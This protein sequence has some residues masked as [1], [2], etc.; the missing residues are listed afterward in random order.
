MGRNGFFGNFQGLDAF[1]KTME[2]VKI[3]TRTGA[4]LTFISFSIILTSMMLEFVDYRRIHLEPSI[5]VD[6]SRGE[7]LV[8]E[9]DVSFPRVPCYLLS[10]DVMDI[11]GEHQTELEHHITKKRL[12]KDGHV[13]ESIEGGQLKGDV[14]RANLK[15]DPNYCGSCY[16]AS[17]P[18]NGCCNSCE[19]VRQAY[20]RKGWS[21][22]DPTGIEQCVEEGWM[23]KMK[24]QNTEGC[25]ISGR[26]RVNK[27]I[28]NIHFSPGR[29]FQNNMMQMLE[30]VP[31]L[32][33]ANHHDFGHIIHKFRFAADLT[34]AD[35]E[36]T[37]PKELK[38]RDSLKMRDPLQEIAAHTEESNYMFQYFLK[39]VSTNF[40]SLTGEEIPSHQYSVTQ[41]ERDLRSGNA[42]GKDSHGHMTSHGVMGV[43]G[44]FFN[45]D[46]SPIRVIHTE[47]RQSFAHFLTSSCAIIG[48]V[49]TVAGLIDSFIFSSSKRIKGMTDD[50]FAGP[51]GKML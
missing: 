40:V 12:S 47:T 37:V 41:Y 4:L 10:L 51:S 17:P 50:G 45:Y 7:K 49:L 46:I 38:W 44:V 25:Q 6:R 9:F 48:G 42:P 28:G 35:E 5:M 43:P 1:G 19:E 24:E 30:L 31:Y 8:I 11:S 34:A 18:E 36:K 39:V 27:V 16:G 3:K 2:D 20:V 15:Q 32:K 33:D 13:L 29:S 26:V 14:E 22:N 21:F 23:D